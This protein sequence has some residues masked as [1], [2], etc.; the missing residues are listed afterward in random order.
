MIFGDCNDFAIEAKI[1]EHLTAPSAP[2]SRM[3]IWMRGEMIGNLEDP[4]CGLEAVFQF[5]DAASSLHNLWDDSLL[6]LGDV[7]IFRHLDQAL[8]LDDDR[9]MEEIKA[10]SRRYSRFNF[11]DNW[12]EMFDQVKA[13]IV[14]PPNEGIII[15]F[16]QADYAISSAHIDRSKFMNSV[17]SLV[18]WYTLQEKRLTPTTA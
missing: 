13:F 11:L 9:S 8:Y 5:K 15:V 12:G 7:E 16:Q 18:S 3:C 2:W 4:H 1:E 17:A 6:G 14:A 10:D